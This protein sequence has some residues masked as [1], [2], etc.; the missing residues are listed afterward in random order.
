MDQIDKDLDRTY[1]P[2]M[3][4]I[5]RFAKLIGCKRSDLIDADKS[6][7]DAKLFDN[8]DIKKYR[9][10]LILLKRNTKKVLFAYAKLDPEIGYV[11]GMNSIAG[12]IIY[13]IHIAKKELDKNKQG[14]AKEKKDGLEKENRKLIDFEKMLPF[15]INYDEE[16]AFFIF[17]GLMKYTNMRKYFQRGMS[18]LQ[19]RIDEVEHYFSHV[20]PDLHQKMCAEMEVSPNHLFLKYKY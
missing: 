15:K 17:Y 5:E 13:N 11:Q 4:K 20:L 18:Y 3:T 2:Q 7:I 1:F 14:I 6:T 10:E 12:A 16:D 9:E 19:T 8:K